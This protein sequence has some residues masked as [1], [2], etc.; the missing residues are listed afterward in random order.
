[1]GIL[2]QVNTNKFMHTLKENKEMLSVLVDMYPHIKVSLVSYISIFKA[3]ILVRGMQKM[4]L[5]KGE[6]EEEVLKPLF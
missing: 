5:K 2:L 3:Q 4:V 6:L 1:M